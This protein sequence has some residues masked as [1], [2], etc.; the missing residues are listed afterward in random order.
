MSQVKE[1]EMKRKKI[2]EQNDWKRVALL[3]KSE[4]EAKAQMKKLQKAKKQAAALEAKRQAELMF[5]G[6]EASVASPVAGKA[7]DVSAVANE[8]DAFV[9]DFFLCEM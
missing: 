8:V 3:A 4:K 1:L 7:A 2:D 6:L 5:Q 9:N